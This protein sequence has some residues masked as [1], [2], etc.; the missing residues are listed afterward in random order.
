MVSRITSTL[1]VYKLNVDIPTIHGIARFAACPTLPPKTV[2]LGIDFGHEK[3]VQLVN[4]IKQNPLTVNTVT[5]AMCAEDDLSEHVSE[6]LHASEGC[7]PI[8]FEDISE[9][10]TVADNTISD[11]LATE[12]SPMLVAPVP[13][14]HSCV[15]AFTFI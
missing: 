1:P 7:C 12:H 9:S 10:V 2:L 8:P 6:A 4:S 14:T 11:V 3:F 15:I 5:R 13:R